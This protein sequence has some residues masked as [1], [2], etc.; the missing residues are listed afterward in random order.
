MF[1]YQARKYLGAYAAALG[2]L[3]TVVF[4]GGIGENAAT[5]RAAN[6]RRARVSGNTARRGAA[7]R[8]MPP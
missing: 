7:T 4:A 3:D 2:G 1:C 6:L 8:R 5:I